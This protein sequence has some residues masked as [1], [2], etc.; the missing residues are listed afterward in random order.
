MTM[1]IPVLALLLALPIAAQ[2]APKPPTPSAELNAQIADLKQ[3]L[4]EKDQ[5]IQELKFRVSI[6]ETPQVI[7]QRY[8]M[9]TKV[10]QAKDAA[11]M[12]HATTEANKAQPAPGGK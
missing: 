5:Q 10:Q 9:Q 8:Q 12:A 3:Q 11:V 4:A 7:A 6:D 2:T 1:K